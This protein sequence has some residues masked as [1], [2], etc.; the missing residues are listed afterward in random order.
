M[1]LSMM[2]QCAMSLHE[3]PKPT[4]YN[5]LSLHSSESEGAVNK[6]IVGNTNINT[7]SKTIV[8]VSQLVC[9]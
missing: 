9:Y 7:C 3:A 4:F 1:P 2:I 6:G 8:V 5:E